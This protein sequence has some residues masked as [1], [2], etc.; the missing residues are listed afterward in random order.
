MSLIFF[1]LIVWFFKYLIFVIAYD[2]SQSQTT[3]NENQRSV[4]KEMVG[5][6]KDK[7]KHE[8]EMD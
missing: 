1:C 8:A 7:R 6:K 3:K 5:E 2:N 4:R